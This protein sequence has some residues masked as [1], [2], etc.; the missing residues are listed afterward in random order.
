MRVQL[1]FLDPKV[2]EKRS[3]VSDEN[4]TSIASLAQFTQTGT[5]E[6]PPLAYFSG[7][8]KTVLQTK[9]FHS[10]AVAAQCTRE[11]LLCYQHQ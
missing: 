9:G 8:L 5:V 3:N 2:Q 4:P 11:S 6:A 10:M 7:L 1:H